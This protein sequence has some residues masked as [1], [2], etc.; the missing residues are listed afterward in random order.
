MPN[1]EYRMG[2]NRRMQGFMLDGQVPKKPIKPRIVT[3]GGPKKVTK[4]KVVKKKK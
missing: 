2:S 3:E 4:K 1:S